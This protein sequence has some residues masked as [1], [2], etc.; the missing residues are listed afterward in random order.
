VFTKELSLSDFLEKHLCEIYYID[1]KF[2]QLSPAEKFVKYA[3]NYLS[4]DLLSTDS[5]FIIYNEHPKDGCHEK[6]YTSIKDFETFKSAL[7][8]SNMALL[9]EFKH[10]FDEGS[11]V[12]RLNIPDGGEGGT[13]LSTFARGSFPE[14][15]TKD[16]EII[17]E[18]YLYERDANWSVL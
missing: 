14:R 17:D 16:F 12:F 1:K 13:L 18:E 3:L 4:N 6:H 9:D 7:D 11:Q 5:S 15:K 10:H 2:E 8:I